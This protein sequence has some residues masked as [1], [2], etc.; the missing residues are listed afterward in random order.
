MFL[1]GAKLFALLSM[2]V[3]LVGFLAVLAGN[4]AQGGISLS[5]SA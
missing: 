5:G 1:D 3:I 2:P 4:F